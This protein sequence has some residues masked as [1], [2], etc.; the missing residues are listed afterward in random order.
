MFRFAANLSMM[1]QEHAFLDR[2]S[3]AKQAGFHAVEFLFPYAYPAHEIV[4]CLEENE[5]ELVLFNLPAGD[6]DAGERG[7]SIYPERRGEFQATVGIALQYAQLLKVKQLHVMAGTI[8]PGEDLAAMRRTYIDNLRKTAQNAREQGLN[9]LIEPLNPRDMPGYFLRTCS[10]AAQIIAEVNEPNLK[11]QFDMYHVQITEGDV[12]TRLKEYL[13]LIGHVQIAGVPD[14]HEP[15]IGEVHFPWL[16][17]T[18]NDL[19]YQG[20]IGCEYRPKEKTEAGLAWLHD[21]GANP[22]SGSLIAL[23][24]NCG[25]V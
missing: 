24:G 12:T 11:L 19:G 15:N 1:F 10:Q 16:L 9:V 2:F 20:F 8:K 5:L 6:W 7:L 25:A 14:R 17:N 23:P 13:P 4:K 18:L 3:A 22:D 21:Y